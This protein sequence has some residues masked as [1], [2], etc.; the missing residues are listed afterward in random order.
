MEMTGGAAIFNDGHRVTNGWFGGATRGGLPVG[1][2]G[3]AWGL[4]FGF[5]F[6]VLVL[7]LGLRLG[8]W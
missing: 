3:L 2:V 8:C 1:V 7:G 6:K 5:V 4:G